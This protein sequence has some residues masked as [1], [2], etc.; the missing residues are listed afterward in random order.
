MNSALKCLLVLCYPL[1]GW[2]YQAP[3]T[4]QLED[5]M[6]NIMDRMARLEADMETKEE[7]IS[8]MRDE[9]KAKNEMV[10]IMKEDIEAMKE[11]LEAKDVE[12]KTLTEV[13]SP[14]YGFQCAWREGEWTADNSILTYDRL[15][16]DE[17]SGGD[18]NTHNVTGG[19]DVT[20]G[21]FT[22]GRGMSG[23]WSVTFS[24]VSWQ[25]DGARHGKFSMK[26]ATRQPSL[27]D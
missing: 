13:R 3:E 2:T 4:A 9:M 6:T 21:V 25:Q 11:S 5:T 7:T 10:A 23:V 1:P 8:T 19:M 17:M 14:P 20:T 12:I 27:L 26:G 18:S 16:Y 15:T 24:A 22:V